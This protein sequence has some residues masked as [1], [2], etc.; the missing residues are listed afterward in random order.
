MISPAGAPQQLVLD[1]PH[2]EAHGAE[3]FLVSRCNE[4]AVRIIDSWPDWPGQAVLIVALRG[5]G[6]T[7]L[8]NVWRIQAGADIIPARDLSDA[9]VSALDNDAARIVEDIDREP[10]DETALFHLLN[11]SKEKG[12]SLFLTARTLPGHWTIGLPDLRSRLRSLPVVTIEPPDEPLLK[13]VLVKLFNDRQIVV[14]PHVVDFIGLRMERSMDW[15]QML[16][17]AIDKAAL[18]GG[19]KVT[20]QLAS[21]VLNRLGA[22]ECD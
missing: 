5:C 1:L 22:S 11:L 18:S 12:F 3:D 8:A 2:R 15:V 16:V 21:E 17:D 6:K 13:A 9:A 14:S 10:Y 19:R 4:A 7:H 20:R